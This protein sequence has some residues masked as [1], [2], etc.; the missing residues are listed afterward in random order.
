[1]MAI[2][3]INGWLVDLSGLLSVL[4]RLRCDALLRCFTAMLYW[5]ISINYSDFFE[6]YL[7][8]NSVDRKQVH[9]L[10]ISGSCTTGD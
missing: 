6:W 4:F 10:A 5:A 1:M 3:V 8:I 7:L 9:V 2:N